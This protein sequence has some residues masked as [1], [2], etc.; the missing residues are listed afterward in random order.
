MFVFISGFWLWY[1][2]FK[3]TNSVIHMSRCFWWTF[4]LVGECLKRQKINSPAAASY[5]CGGG[6]TFFHDLLLNSSFSKKRLEGEVFQGA[7]CQVITALIGMPHAHISTKKNSTK[8]SKSLAW[9][10][11]L[12]LIRRACGQQQIRSFNMFL[13]LSVL[14]LSLFLSDHGHVS[15]PRCPSLSLGTK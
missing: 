5:L 8:E 9:G 1:F 12:H 2:F 14:L 13:T 4:S 11:C 15:P 6:S 10:S 3:C 7:G